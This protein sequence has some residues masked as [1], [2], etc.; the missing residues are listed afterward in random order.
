MTA[1]SGDS[2]SRREFSKTVAAAGVGLAIPASGVFAAG[3]DTIRVAMVGCG[4]RGTVDAVYCL[5]SA[6]G[7]ELVAIA[8]LFSR[9]RPSASS[10]GSTPTRRSSRSTT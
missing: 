10:S 9:S 8:D 4:D 7:A 1:N 2:L 6:P 5:K 3:S